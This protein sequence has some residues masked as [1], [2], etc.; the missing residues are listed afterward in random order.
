LGNIAMILGTD[1]KWDPAKEQVIGNNAAQW[2][3]NRPQRAPWRL[4]A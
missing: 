4:E 1:L 2:M 3:V